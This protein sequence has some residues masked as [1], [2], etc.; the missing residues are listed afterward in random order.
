MI[1]GG[2]SASSYPAGDCFPATIDDVGFVDL[3]TEDVRLAPS[4]P[5]AASAAN[6]GPAGAGVAQMLRLT[7]DVD[8]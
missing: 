8:G 3:A 7:G 4:S 6:G 1:L 2:A 5:Y